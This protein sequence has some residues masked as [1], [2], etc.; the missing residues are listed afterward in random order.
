MV[1]LAVFRVICV[2]SV[3]SRYVVNPRFPLTLSV[4]VAPRSLYVVPMLM[5]AG[6]LPF[7]VMTGGS[8]SASGVV[9]ACPPESPSGESGVVVATEQAPATEMSEPFSIFTQ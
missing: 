2:T 5:L 8:V 3:P 1:E 4:T 7:I 9:V 6:L